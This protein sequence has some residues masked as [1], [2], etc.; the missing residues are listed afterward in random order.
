M[1][2]Y[3]DYITDL[4]RHSMVNYNGFKDENYNNLISRLSKNAMQAFTGLY[5]LLENSSKNKYMMNF[6]E[7]LI[8]SPENACELAHEILGDQF[9]FV[10]K[11]MLK[12]I[13]GSKLANFVLSV[14]KRNFSSS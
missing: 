10:I 13:E 9:I 1:F 12:D 2:Q 11:V 8:R 6:A 3:E 14:C 7:L 5:I 4:R